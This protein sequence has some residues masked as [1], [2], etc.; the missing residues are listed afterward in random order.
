VADQEQEYEQALQL[1]Y[2]G[3]LDVAEDAIVTVDEQQR[4]VMFNRGAER[5]FGL[6]RGEVRGQSLDILIPPRYETVHRQ[7]VDEFARSTIVSRW[8]GERSEVYGRRKDGSEFPADV[9]ISKLAVQ[10]KMYLTAIVRDVT[11]RKRTQEAILTLNRDLEHRVAER[12]AELQRKNEEIRTT[13]QQLW[14]AAKLASVGELA[15]GIAHELNNPLGIISLRLEAV[16]A[17]TP[18]GDPRRS[19]LEI[20]EQELDR[21]SSLVA[22][23]LQFSRPGREAVSSVDLSE[24]MNRTLDLMHH[25]M[26]KRG[27]D[28]RPV[29]GPEH[30]IVLADRQ[31]LR[32]VFLNLVANACDAMSAGGTLTLRIQRQPLGSG[33]QGVM[34]EFVDT[35]HGIPPEVLPKVMDPFFSTKEEGKGTGL[36]LAI[37]RRIVQEHRG[38]IRIDSAVGKGTTVRIALPVHSGVNVDG[39]N[40][41]N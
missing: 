37:C 15:A 32:Q 9:S 36:G 5:I 29:Y 25:Q 23:L 35:G 28:V 10:G 4:I 39:L 21:M 7:Y 19:A 30:Q 26:R 1:H 3:L 6:S 31:K 11:E 40:P 34:I 16:L 33:A 41:T 2:A 17:K 12:T 38:T 27:I 8:M 20:I 13:T 14:H 18:P 24:E 22:N